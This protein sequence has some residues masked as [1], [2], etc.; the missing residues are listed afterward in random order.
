MTGCSINLAQRTECSICH[1]QFV[2]NL[3]GFKDREQSPGPDRGCPNYGSAD[4]KKTC[5]DGLISRGR[6]VVY[7]LQAD[8]SA[9]KSPLAYYSTA[10]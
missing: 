7:W 9:L 2:L 6:P 1:C 8:L 4:C 10:I 3:S 5:T